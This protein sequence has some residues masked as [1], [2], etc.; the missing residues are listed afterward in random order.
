MYER[1]DG[2]TKTIYPFK[3]FCMPVSY[4]ILTHQKIDPCIKVFFFEKGVRVLGQLKYG[5]KVCDRPRIVN[6]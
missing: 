5:D 2:M 1:A 6:S 4:S 3:I